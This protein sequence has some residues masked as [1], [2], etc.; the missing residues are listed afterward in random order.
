MESAHLLQ[1]GTDSVSLIQTLLLFFLKVPTKQNSQSFPSFG[2]G[3][4]EFLTFFF[5]WSGK[6]LEPGPYISDAILTPTLL[7][8]SQHELALSI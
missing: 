3:P 2:G 6:F 5:L 4:S 7:R 8:V 1:P